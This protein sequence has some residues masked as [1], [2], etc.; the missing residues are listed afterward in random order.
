MM[1]YYN[2]K[3]YYAKPRGE[4]YYKEKNIIEKISEKKLPSYI[5]DLNKRYHEI[6]GIGLGELDKMD[7]MHKLMGIYHEIR[8][9]KSKPENKQFFGLFP[10]GTPEL[11]DL[12]REKFRLEEELKKKQ[13]ELDMKRSSEQDKGDLFAALELANKRLE[14][15]NSKRKNEEILKQK[16]SVIAEYEGK[17]RK[18]ARSVKTKLP[19]NPTCPYCGKEIGKMAHADHIYPISKGGRSTISNMVYICNTCN[20]KKSDMTLREFILE[21]KL[22]R[23]MIERNLESLGK[24]F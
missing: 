23:D 10:K 8:C 6:K 1:R 22:N 4:I 7:I 24:S 12:E 11:Y 21:Y 16:T 15:I 13:S 3:R 2:N 9:V 19:T 5:E 17:S 14:R 18:I 20:I